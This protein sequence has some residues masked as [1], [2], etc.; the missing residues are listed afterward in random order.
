M[1]AE[2]PETEKPRINPWSVW[3][4]I[5]FIMLGVVILY[6]YTVIQTMRKDND[7]PPYLTQIRDDLDLVERSGEKVKLSQ[8]SG[9]IILAAHFY[10]TCPSGCSVLIDE[11]KG[12]YDQYAPTHPN[13][14]FISFA[15]DPGD[16][17]ERLKEAAEGYGVKGQNWWFVNGDQPTIR[18]FLTHKM[19]FYKLEEKPK[20]QQT[21]PIDKYNHDMR[22]A[23]IDGEGH[24]RGMYEV[25]NPDPEFRQ[26]YQKKLRKDLDYLLKEAETKK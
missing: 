3:I 26:I 24:L 8:L 2:T 6:N 23:L 10:S 21:S 16:T 20:E 25:L 22:I 7:R 14:Q 4:P 1:T 13:L 19:K 18:T 11:M 9:K 12:I 5:I 17:P 15:I